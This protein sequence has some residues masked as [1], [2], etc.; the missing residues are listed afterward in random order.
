MI[1]A[2]LRPD[3]HGAKL[4]KALKVDATSVTARNLPVI[5]A[6]GFAESLL[7]LGAAADA[8]ATSDST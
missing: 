8:E 3:E 4:A 6:S 7:E 2:R 1:Y 5:D